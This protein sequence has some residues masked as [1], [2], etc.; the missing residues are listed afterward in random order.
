MYMKKVILN[1]VQKF[2][3]DD[4]LYGKVKNLCR[5]RSD[6]GGEYVSQEFEEVLTDNKIRH[7]FSA[8]YTP[9]QNGTAE[10]NWRTL[11][12]MARAMLIESKLPRNL[13]TYA[14]MTA[15]HIRN[16]MYCQRIHDTPYH[17]LTGKQPAM[18]KLHVFGSVCYSNVHQKTK[19]D[20]RSQKGLFVGYDKYSPSYLIYYPE[21]KTV[22]KNGTVT[23]TERFE[24]IPDHRIASDSSTNF[25]P[26]YA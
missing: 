25:S 22:L 18:S 26:N 9:H 20:P 4:A 1:G 15:A 13:W 10:R 16:R 2:I 19:L 11:F 14:I 5:M 17:L 6:N 7:E 12:E 21:S 24:S 23:F 8:P 3:A